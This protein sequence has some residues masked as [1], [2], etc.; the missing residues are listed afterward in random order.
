MN[1]VN[2]VLHPPSCAMDIVVSPLSTIRP[3]ATM[4]L[5]VV[6]AL[7]T[8]PPTRGDRGDFHYEIGDVSG[9]WA[10]V[11]LVTEDKGRTLAPP[12]E[13]LLLGRTVDSVHPALDEQDPEDRT[14][15]YALFPDLA[16]AEPGTYCLRVTLIDMDR[17]VQILP[18]DCLTGLRHLATGLCSGSQCRA[19]GT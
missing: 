9:I 12:R 8:P 16:I 18:H 14:V 5:P 15:G 10:F 17:S 2:N 13:D 6:V 19:A 7:R 4:P 1:H 11:S 3:G